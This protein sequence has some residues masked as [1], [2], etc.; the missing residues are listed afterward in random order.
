MRRALLL[1]PFLLAACGGGTDGF[2]IDNVSLS[3]DDVP[4]DTT[5]VEILKMGADVFDDLHDVSAVWVVSQQGP[6]WLDLVR[7]NDAH[8]SASVPLTALHG[9]PSG[10]YVLDVHAQDEAGRSIVLAGAVRLRIG[11]D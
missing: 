5:G 10:N 2:R 6:F 7:G 8:W 9:F 11:L 3:P 1:L 4:I